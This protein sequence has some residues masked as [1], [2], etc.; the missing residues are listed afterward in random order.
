MEVMGV[1]FGVLIVTLILVSAGRELLRRWPLHRI[2]RGLFAVSAFLGLYGL[3]AFFAQM[4]AAMGGLWFIGPSVEWPVGEADQVAHTSDGHMLVPVIPSG[5]VQVYD[6]NGR[7]VR[8]WFVH[9]SGGDFKVAPTSDGGVA[10]FTA[11]GNRR[12]LYTPSGALL[13]EATYSEAYER[14][15]AASG[16]TGRFRYAWPLWPL[17]HPFAAWGTGVVGMLGIGAFG[18]RKRPPNDQMQLT[19]P[20]NMKRRSWSGR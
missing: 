5:R 1:V 17:S 3:V 12:I 2:Q 20:A 16:D 6:D 13:E 8:G 18:E 11:R 10:V 7:F 9:A 19:M 15:K 14:V 4:L